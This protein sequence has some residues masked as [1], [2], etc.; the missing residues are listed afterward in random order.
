MRI[1]YPF[2][3]RLFQKHN[4][5]PRHDTEIATAIVITVIVL[6]LAIS[7]TLAITLTGPFTKHEEVT[8][9]QETAMDVVYNLVPLLNG[10]NSST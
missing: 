5:M 4:I 1:L 8:T 7:I 10:S 9:D 6:G 2:I 3:L